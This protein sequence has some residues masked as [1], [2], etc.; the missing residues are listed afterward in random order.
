MPRVIDRSR[1]LGLYRPILIDCHDDDEYRTSR[2]GPPDGAR[3]SVSEAEAR[4][5]REAA[6]AVRAPLLPPTRYAVR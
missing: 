4:L 1:L 2:L 5:T 6:T 3:H